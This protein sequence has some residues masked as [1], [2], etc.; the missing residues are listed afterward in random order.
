MIAKIS[1]GN[2][3]MISTIRCYILKLLEEL[4][5]LIKLSKEAYKGR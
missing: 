2:E 1:G 5:H 3:P 4:F